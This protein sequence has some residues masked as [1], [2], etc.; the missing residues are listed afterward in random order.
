RRT[1]LGAIHRYFGAGGIN[2][3]LQEFHVVLNQRISDLTACMIATSLPTVELCITRAE[4]A[5]SK[6]I[7]GVQR[8]LLEEMHQMSLQAAASSSQQTV[9][10]QQ[11]LDNL[12]E[13]TTLVRRIKVRCSAVARST[14]TVARPHTTDVAGVISWDDV[15]LD[16]GPGA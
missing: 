7:D 4:S 5:L 1:W 9:V 14:S 15:V 10:G 3:Q 2:D 6:R 8:E 16:D 13:L 12:A 11:L